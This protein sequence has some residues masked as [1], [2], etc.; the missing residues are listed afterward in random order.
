MAKP[1][2]PGIKAA[3]GYW[4]TNNY[5]DAVN[6]TVQYLEEVKIY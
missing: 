2:K 5:D 1:L 4:T 6:F 3:T